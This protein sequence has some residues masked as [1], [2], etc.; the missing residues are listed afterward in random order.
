VSTN[1]TAGDTAPAFAAALTSGGVAVNLTGATVALHFTTPADTLTAAA[2][3]VDPAA[4]TISYSWAVTDLTDARVGVWM[5]ETQVTYSNSKT[6][7]FPG[8]VFWV[9]PQLA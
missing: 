2:T 6:Q 3:L 5:W 1:F 9:N 4:G 7:T 8:G